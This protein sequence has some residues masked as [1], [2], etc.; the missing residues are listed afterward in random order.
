MMIATIEITIPWPF[1]VLA[2]VLFIAAAV[3]WSKA[4]VKRRRERVSRTMESLGMKPVEASD[5][6]LEQLWN[7]LRIAETGCTPTIALAW[8]RDELF[9]QLYLLDLWMDDEQQ[10]RRIVSGYSLAVS[11]HLDMPRFS[12]F[13]KAHATGFIGRAAKFIQTYAFNR[14]GQISFVDAPEFD[15]HYAVVGNDETAI[16]QFLTTACLR[17]L[18]RL[19]GRRLEADG[20]MFIYSRSA[21]NKKTSAQEETAIYE[22]IE[23]V[24]TL[25][26]V[27]AES[28]ARCPPQ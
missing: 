14:L 4:Q 11:N 21:L 8:K 10:E 26:R 5:P 7:R 15:Q 17:E 22:L 25:Y 6:E 24:K 18:T 20:D 12:L 19:K 23:E 13:A 2:I 27:F 9:G 16:R 28:S 3:I 1:A